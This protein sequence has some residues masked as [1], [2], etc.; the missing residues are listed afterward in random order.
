MK[1]ALALVFSSAP[2]SA[3]SL[4]GVADRSSSP[5]LICGAAM[6]LQN[7]AAK[8]DFRVRNDRMSGNRGPARTVEHGEKRTLRRHRDGGRQM[9]DRG[10]KFTGFV[11]ILPRLNGDGALPNG[12][13]KFVIEKTCV[14]VSGKAQ[15]VQSGHAKN[16]GVNFA[17]IDFA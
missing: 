12:R 17:V 7:H 16:G 8:Y 3:P 11:V 6:R 9:I 4:N 10:Q 5:C 1:P 2:A 13:Q 14:T 15:T